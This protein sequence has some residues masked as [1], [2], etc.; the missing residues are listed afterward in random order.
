LQ[1]GF[2]R[3]NVTP[4]YDVSLHGYG[5]EK[6]R[7]TSTFTHY[8]Y[9]TCIAAKYG[10]DTI[11]FYTL[12]IGSLR[13]GVPELIRQSASEAT[14]IPGENIFFGATHTHSGPSLFYDSA[15]NQRYQSEYYQHIALLE[16]H[17]GFGSIDDRLLRLGQYIVCAGIAFAHFTTAYREQV[18]VV[19]FT[20]IDLLQRFANPFIRQ[21]YICQRVRGIYLAQAHEALV[22]ETC[23][24]LLGCYVLHTEELCNA[25]ELENLAV[26]LVYTAGVQVFDSELLELGCDDDAAFL[27]VFACGN[28]DVG[29]I[30]LEV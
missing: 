11:L 7:I 18:D 23:C 29:I 19:L 9:I 27:G 2:S 1:I 20:H 30:I 13:N 28:D 24:E 25:D 8:I 17:A 4:T 16:L 22:D 5:E 6:L 15:A 3:I 10:E 14:G 12:D 26:Q 21:A